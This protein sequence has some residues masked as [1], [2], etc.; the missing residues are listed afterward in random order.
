MQLVCVQ[1][2][3]I[4]KGKYPGK[5]IGAILLDKNGIAKKWKAS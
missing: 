1:N 3:C 4:C 2:F 5:L